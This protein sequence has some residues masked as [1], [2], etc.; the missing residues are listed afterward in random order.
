MNGADPP[1]GRNEIRLLDDEIAELTYGATRMFYKGSYI[2]TRLRLTVR[3]P[4]AAIGYS[5]KV[6]NMDADLDELRDRVAK[7]IAD[8]MLGE[9]R[10]AAAYTG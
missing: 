7:K 1:P 9:L 6:Q 4:R 10:A 3:G 8:R 2:G 5:A